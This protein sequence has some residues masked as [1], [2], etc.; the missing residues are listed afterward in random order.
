MKTEE[1]IKKQNP[2]CPYCL[3]DPLVFTIR[4]IQFG[5]GVVAMIAFCATPECRKLFSVSFKS[6]PPTTRLVLPNV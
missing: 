6:G 4:D 5:N 3:A 1:E 2:V